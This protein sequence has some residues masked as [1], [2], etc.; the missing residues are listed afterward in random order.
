MFGY[1][2]FTRDQR[3]GTALS[4]LGV[5][6]TFIAGRWLVYHDWVT[7]LLP[8]AGALASWVGAY[9]NTRQRLSRG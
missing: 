8:I 9:F 3:I 7:Y 1:P 4:I 6:T 2:P 5:L